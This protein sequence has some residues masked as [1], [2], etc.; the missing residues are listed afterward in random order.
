MPE[1]SNL[2]TGLKR[3]GIREIMDMALGMK[4]IVRLEVGEPLFA[5]PDHIVE[6]GVHAAREGYTKYTANAGILSLREAIAERLKGDYNVKLSPDNIIITVGGVGAVSTAVRALTDIGDEVLIPDP[7]WPNYEMIISVAGA[8]PKRYK[9]RPENGFR[10]SISDL[11]KA[12][13]TKTKA[14]LINSPSNPLG[15][16]FPPELMA[17]LVEFAQKRNLF[18]ISDEVYEKIIFRGKHTSALSFDTDGRVVSV[19]S[20]SKTYAMTGW[21]VGYAV[22]A[23][24]I[25]EQMIKLQEAYVACAPSISQKAAEVAIKGPQDCVEV[26]CRTYFENLKLAREI[27]DHHGIVYQIPEGAFYLWIDAGCR[28]STEFAKRLLLEKKVSL[29]PGRTFGPSGERYVRVSLASPKESIQ[30]GLVRMADFLRMQQE[31]LYHAG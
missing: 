28:D 18:L 16:V 6:A 11:D 1:L 25:I 21:R 22:A 9:L 3:S 31:L 27:L 23:V 10:P 17:E 12:L 24:P 8:V 26:M 2:T 7:G 14:I 4:D 20:V 19:F 15:T 13:T 30:E 29:A 5:T